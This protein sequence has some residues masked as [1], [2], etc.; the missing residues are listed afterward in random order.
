ASETAMSSISNPT[1]KMLRRT[2]I[3]HEAV[4]SIDRTKRRVIV[5]HGID[6]SHP[7]A[8]HY[9]H[10]VLALGSVT[11]FYGI[12]GLEERALTMKSLADAVY[13]RNR[14]IEHLE[15]ADFECSRTVRQPLLTFVVAGG[16]FAGVETAA[17]INDF[18][19]EAL[20]FY[21]N[22]TAEM[23]RVVLVEATWAILP[24]LGPE[25]GDYAQKKPAG[26]GIEFRLTT[27][28]EGRAA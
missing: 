24:E 17:A 6:T 20:K 18:L 7:H 13:L 9:D 1:R 21:P 10:L 27:T 25:L 15:E 26:R 11:N 12:P 14:L 22:L 2:S 3:V 8:L 19:R 16:G 23:L 4:S 5:S 28:V